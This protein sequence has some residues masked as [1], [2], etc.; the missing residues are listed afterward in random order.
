MAMSAVV[1]IVGT[2]IDGSSGSGAMSSSSRL[3]GVH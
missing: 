3:L 2:L 1:I